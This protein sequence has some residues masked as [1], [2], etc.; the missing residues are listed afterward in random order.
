LSEYL[1]LKCKKQKQINN[2]NA[3]I[4]FL[5]SW[6]WELNGEALT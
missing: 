6:E 5:K 4:D 2:K 3:K 1:E